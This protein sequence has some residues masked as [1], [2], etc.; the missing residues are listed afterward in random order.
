MFENLLLGLLA[1]V[2]TGSSVTPAAENPL[3]AREAADKIRSGSMTS[4]ALTRELLA[5]AE[6]L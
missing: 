4:E 1:A 3:S 2:L 6:A 5:R